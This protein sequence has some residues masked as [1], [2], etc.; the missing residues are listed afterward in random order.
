[1][2]IHFVRITREDFLSKSLLHK[3]MPLENALR[4]LEDK[5]L[6]FSNPT[7]WPDPFEKRFIEGTYEGKPFKWKGRV[8]C[9]CMTETATSEAYWKTY[10]QQSIGVSF[11]IKRFQLL[12]E[13]ETIQDQYDIYIGKAEYKPTKLIRKPLKQIP[14]DKP[15]PNFG[16]PEFYA[17]ML[18]LKRT[19]FKYEDEIRMMIL[20]KTP[21][22]ENGFVLK[23]RCE[24]TDLIRTITLDPSL[25]EYTF[26]LFKDIF[27]EK[28][29]FATEGFNY[30]VQQSKL[31]ETLER[32]KIKLE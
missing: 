8:F 11:A 5:S 19:A 21:T 24:N 26:K 4:T 12:T 30:R 10:S 22:K 16:T 2:A 25:K 29:G 9:N 15:V 32:E 27:I 14:F 7:C 13:L 31:Y 17:R 23:Y 3:Y 6:W 1:M 20:K 18:L 28:Y